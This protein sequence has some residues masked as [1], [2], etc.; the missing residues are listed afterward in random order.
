VYDGEMISA[1]LWFS[2]RFKIAFG[3][4]FDACVV[5]NRSFIGSCRRYSATLVA[6]YIERFDEHTLAMDDKNQYRVVRLFLAKYEIELRCFRVRIRLGS[7]NNH[8]T[9]LQEVIEL[10]GI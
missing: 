7:E 2:D 1:M 8:H 10:D 6:I 4:A 9:V 3:E 5:M